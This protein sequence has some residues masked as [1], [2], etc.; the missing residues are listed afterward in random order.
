MKG[1]QSSGDHYQAGF[2]RDF[3]TVGIE[4]FKTGIGIKG[5]GNLP[6]QTT[7]LAGKKKIRSSTCA[8]RALKTYLVRL[9]NVVL[10]SSLFL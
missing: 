8:N 5:G 10:C 9:F 1:R 2:K 7:A 4:S 6:H 3:T